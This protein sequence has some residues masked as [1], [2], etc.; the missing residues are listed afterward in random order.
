MYQEYTN[1]QI[2]G[3]LTMALIE[4]SQKGKVG[5]QARQPYHCGK[6]YGLLV[7]C[8]WKVVMLMGLSK[9][10]WEKWCNEYYNQACSSY[11]K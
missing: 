8:N 11:I 7:I 5:E 3:G 9:Y 1:K 6:V 2:H 10:E 4:Y